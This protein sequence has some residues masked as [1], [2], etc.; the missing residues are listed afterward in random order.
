M[1]IIP[2]TYFNILKK[3]TTFDNYFLI[4]DAYYNIPKIY[5]M[6]NIITEEV[7]GKLDMFQARF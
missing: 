1:G 3:D 6:E 7:M 5:G 4:L 2:A